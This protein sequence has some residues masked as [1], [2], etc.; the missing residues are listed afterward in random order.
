MYINYNGVSETVKYV[1]KQ[2]EPGFHG[3]LFGIA[4]AS[5]LWDIST[6]KRSMGE[7]KGFNNMGHIDKKS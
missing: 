5:V 7:V 6:E 4:G 3:M 2:Q 1:V